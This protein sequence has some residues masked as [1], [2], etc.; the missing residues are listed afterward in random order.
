MKRASL[1]LLLV[2]AAGCLSALEPDVGPKIAGQCE[3]EDSDTE[4]DVSFTDQVLPMLSQRCGCHDPKG[5]GSAIDSTAFS[6]GTY[7]DLRK[8]GSKSGD[9][10]VVDGDACNSILVQKCSE[11]PP[12][13][14]RMPVGGPYL[15]SSEMAVLRDWIVEGAHEK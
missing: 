14:T 15:S 6:L 2:T 13:G 11:A 9:K 4:N 3:N 8:G 1:C 7:K 10:I 12:Y 5:G